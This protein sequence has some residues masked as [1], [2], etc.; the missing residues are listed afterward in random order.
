MVQDSGILQR[1]DRTQPIS[2]T[3]LGV[4]LLALAEHFDSPKLRTA[5]GNFLERSAGSSLEDKTIAFGDCADSGHVVKWLLFA[6]KNGLSL[7]CEAC[8]TFTAQQWGK[9]RDDQRVLQLST[10]TMVEV[11]N[12]LCALHEG[13]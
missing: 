7:F 1:S 12:A 2:S 5:C 13:E 4:E 8:I 3:R 9:I 11:I 10:N 6:E